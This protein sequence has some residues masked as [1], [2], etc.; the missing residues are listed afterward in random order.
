M[1][2]PAPA[3]RKPAPAIA[4][5]E[6]DDRTVLMARDLRPSVPAAARPATRRSGL[7]WP[8]LFCLI[9]LGLALVALLILLWT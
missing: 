4:R 3:P 9:S 2:R 1:P 8:A 5:S 6:D 7:F